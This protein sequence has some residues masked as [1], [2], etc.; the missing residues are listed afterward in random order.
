MSLLPRLPAPPSRRSTAA[1]ITAIAGLLSAFAAFRRQPPEPMAKESYQVLQKAFIEQG[2]ELDEVRKDLA[3]LRTSFEEYL[4]AKEGP[5][6]VATEPNG[7]TKPTK[8]QV[9]PS[10]PA[11]PTAAPPVKAVPTSKPA[12]PPD[13]SV[14]KSKAGL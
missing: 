14:L 11:T 9:Q 6:N 13:Y 12:P 3:T 10:P 1:L 7:G 4:K 2:T 5:S 8:V